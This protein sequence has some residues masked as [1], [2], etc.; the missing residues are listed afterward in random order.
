MN[1]KSNNDVTRPHNMISTRG[2]TPI[3]TLNCVSQL[4][5]TNETIN[6]QSYQDIHAIFHSIYYNNRETIKC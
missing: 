3:D 1:K 6:I 2:T 4:K 5:R